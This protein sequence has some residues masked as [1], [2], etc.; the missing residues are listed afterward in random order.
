MTPQLREAVLTA[1]AHKALDLKVLGLR[2]VCS[3][4]DFFLLCSGT[5][6]RHSQAIS[7]AIR[8]QL[9]KSRAIP[10]HVEGYAQGE[11]IL[12]DYGEFVVHIFS[13][14]AREFYGLERLWK[15]AAYFPAPEE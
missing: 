13:R 10:G 5:S 14:R 11:W 4:T 12:M 8:E 15:T 9:Q 6:S 7:D 1:Q 3:F 2:G